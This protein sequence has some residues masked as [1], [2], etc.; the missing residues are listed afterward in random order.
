MLRIRFA[1]AATVLLV[2]GAAVV[3]L[4]TTSVA[5]PMA[6]SQTPGYWLVGADGGVFSFDA[7]FFG[8]S[9]S[10]C[11]ASSAPFGGPIFCATA[12]A[13][14]PDG[15]GYTILTP[16]EFPVGPSQQP[17]LA[18]QFGNATG[19]ASCA[20]H[21]DATGGPTSVPLDVGFPWVGIASHRPVTGSGS[22]VRAAR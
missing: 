6:Q 8:S 18:S 4:P 2:S 10:Q 13:S 15:G 12:I 1:I 3:A 14:T 20:T 22:S 21:F 11:A 17:A 16:F 19:D 9:A 7:P 5:E